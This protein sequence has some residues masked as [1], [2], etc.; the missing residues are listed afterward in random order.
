MSPPRTSA[1]HTQMVLNSAMTCPRRAPVPSTH[2]PRQRMGSLHLT[3]EC[4]WCGARW[5]W[6][7]SHYQVTHH[8]A[9]KARGQFE[10]RYYFVR[11]GSDLST[12]PLISDSLSDNPAIAGL[13]FLCLCGWMRAP[14]YKVVQIWPGQTVTCLHTNRPGHIWTTLYVCMHSN[15]SVFQRRMNCSVVSIG[16]YLQ[17]YHWQRTVSRRHWPQF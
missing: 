13:K 12:L 9:C 2:N 8:S 5:R 16:F 17:P 3:L 10:E 11:V 15:M 14:M 4:P 1:K 6:R 7:A